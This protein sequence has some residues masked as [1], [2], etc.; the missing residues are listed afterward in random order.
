MLE[1]VLASQS[2]HL[3][4]KN[5]GLESPENNVDPASKSKL[6]NILAKALFP[7]FLKLVFR[8]QQT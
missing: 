2:L 4:S 7:G 6:L 8:R 5:K 1:E 3:F